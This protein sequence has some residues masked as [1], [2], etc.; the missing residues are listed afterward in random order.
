MCAE[1]EDVSKVRCTSFYH[2]TS[3]LAAMFLLDICNFAK[4]N[5]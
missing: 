3:S 1:I 4:S 5:N 2:A